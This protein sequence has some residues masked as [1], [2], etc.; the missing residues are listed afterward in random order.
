MRRVVDPDGRPLQGALVFPGRWYRL[1]GDD[2][3][4]LMRPQSI[5]DGVTTDAE[6]R[7]R[8]EAKSPF[9]TAWHDDFTPTTVK[10]SD[11]AVIRM[12]ARATL[13]GKLVDAAGKPREGIEV[14]L[15]KRG[16]RAVTDSAG[17]FQFEKVIAGFRGLILPNYRWVA[18]RVDPGET[19]NLE[20]GPGVDVTLDLGDHPLGPGTQIN[21]GL[22]GV[23]RTTSLVGIRGQTPTMDLK[24]VLPGRYLFGEIRGA[25][26]WVDISDKGAKVEFGKATLEITAEAE[27]TFYF[28]PAEAN[29]IIEV[30][31]MKMGE[32]KTGPGAP[33]RMEH[34]MEGDY[35][36][37][38]R[39]G[40]TLERFKVGPGETR[41]TLKSK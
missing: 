15:D 6:G 17:A 28:L 29:E 32:L 26:G 27:T 40:V 19:L 21:G 39:E 14:T 7:F 12:K 33:L 10:T 34:L 16:P 35:E 23:T 30:A 1:R 25:R 9:L 18:V 4:D 36:L 8:L 3:F 5:K 22:M 2:A 37:R 41:V 13:R 20:I 11:A 24:G 38:D 31:I